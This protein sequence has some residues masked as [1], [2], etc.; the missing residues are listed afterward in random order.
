[1]AVY[2][3]VR[4]CKETFL[5]AKLCPVGENRLAGAVN[6]LRCINANTQTCTSN[7]AFRVLTSPFCL[8]FF[9]HFVTSLSPLTP[10]HLFFCICISVPTFFSSPLF[11]FSL[12][13]IVWLTGSLVWAW[14]LNPQA[15]FKLWPDHLPSDIRGLEAW[16][17][18]GMRS[19]KQSQGYTQRRTWTETCT[20]MHVQQKPFSCTHIPVSDCRNSQLFCSWQTEN[21]SLS[22]LSPWFLPC[23]TCVHTHTLTNTPHHPTYLCAVR[24]RERRGEERGLLGVGVLY[25]FK[26]L[27][28]P[29]VCIADRLD[30]IPGLIQSLSQLRPA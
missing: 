16:P 18:L 30:L 23:Y 20:H 6:C 1:M 14:E 12:T 5:K 25:F 11:S 21:K 4:V 10:S 13:L 27:S 15:Q 9:V 3:C 29:V 7:G 24:E 22:I 17:E 8:E 2:L 28:G 19:P 26:G